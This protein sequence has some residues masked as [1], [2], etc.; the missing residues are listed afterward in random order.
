MP[1]G[2]AVG[3]GLVEQMPLTTE[4]QGGVVTTHGEGLQTLFVLDT[5]SQPVSGSC[6]PQKVIGSLRDGPL[7]QQRLRASSCG[8]GSVSGRLCARRAGGGGTNR[9]P[10]VRA[11]LF[12]FFTAT[13]DHSQVVKIKIYSSLLS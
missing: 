11:P 3:L 4:R 6:C 2:M 1:V 10:K 13:D 9:E 7:L 5:V 12:Q 8:C